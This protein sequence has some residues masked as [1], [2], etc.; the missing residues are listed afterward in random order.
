MISGELSLPQQSNVYSGCS[1]SSDIELSTLRSSFLSSGWVPPSGKSL[2]FIT[3][4]TTLSINFYHLFAI[5]SSSFRNCFSEG[6]F[7]FI[8]CWIQTAMLIT[9]PRKDDGNVILPMPFYQL[10]KS[11]KSWN[12]FPSFIRVVFSCLESQCNI[13]LIKLKSMQCKMLLFGY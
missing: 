9:W 3:G 7:S 10:P 12:N 2:F 1:K 5:I 8:F 4:S 13:C 6:S 11:I